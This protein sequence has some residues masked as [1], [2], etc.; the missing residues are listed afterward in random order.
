MINVRYAKI[1]GFIQSLC[2]FLLKK[3]S[4][5]IVVMTLLGFMFG[6]TAIYAKG[7]SGAMV[8]LLTG[9]AQLALPSSQAA[10]AQ[11]M[12]QR[13]WGAYRFGL[14]YVY[15]F[16]SH[17]G[18]GLELGRGDYGSATYHFATNTIKVRDT[19]AEFTFRPEFNINKLT[20]YGRFGGTRNTTTFY[21]D[22]DN[23][24]EQRQNMLGGLGI[25]YAITRHVNLGFDYQHDFGKKLK[26]ITNPDWLAPAF[27][28]YMFGI[29][30]RFFPNHS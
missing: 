11:N 22:R 26:N 25:D 21:S 8:D 18:L 10:T 27:N 23:T 13:R 7:Y 17:I 24:T 9:Y 28:S 2:S 12:S 16:T 15:Y 29:M 14:G 5:L 6:A 20:V 30:I 3:I 19:T 4:L 1:H